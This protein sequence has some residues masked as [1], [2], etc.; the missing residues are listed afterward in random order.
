MLGTLILPK[1]NI[2]KP[3]IKLKKKL[4]NKQ[5]DKIFG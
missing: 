2:G 1:N 4:Y 3:L 5:T